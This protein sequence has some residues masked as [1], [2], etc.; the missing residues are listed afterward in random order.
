MLSIASP[1]SDGAQNAPPPARRLG[2][3][4][5]DRV[6]ALS[7]YEIRLMGPNL[8]TVPSM[9]HGNQPI[10][11]ARYP[12]VCSRMNLTALSSMTSAASTESTSSACEGGSYDRDSLST[13]RSQRRFRPRSR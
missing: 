5:P 4:L 7:R 11:P 6:T 8:G 12:A 9:R 10:R 13:M 2:Y 3:P 1:A